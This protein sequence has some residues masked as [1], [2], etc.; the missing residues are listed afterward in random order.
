MLFSDDPKEAMD[1]AWAGDRYYFAIHFQQMTGFKRVE[2]RLDGAQWVYTASDTEH[3]E[4]GNGIYLHGDQ[5]HLEPVYMSVQ[6]EGQ[7]P[8][9]LVKLAGVFL[10]YDMS[11]SNA[12]PRRCQVRGIL[13]PRVEIK[14]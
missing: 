7:A 13:A 10:Q 4:N 6:V 2:D 5:M 3:E 8:N 9:L 14:N 11:D 12:K 1:K